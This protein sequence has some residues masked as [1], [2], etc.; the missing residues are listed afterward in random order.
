RLCTKSVVGILVV[1]FLVPSAILLAP[2]P[3][4][5]DSSCA[6][7]VAGAVAS[8]PT[9]AAAEK[10][11]GVTTS[12]PS[13]AVAGSVGAGSSFGTFFGNCILKPIA[14]RLAKAMLQN[15]TQSIVTWINN[16]FKNPD[17]S[18]SPSFVQNFSGLI[19]QTTDQVIGNFLTSDLGAGFLCSSFSLQVKIAI[20][21]SYLPYQQTGQCTLSQIENNVNGFIQND[22]SGGW[23]NW[24]QVTTVP[25]NNVWGATI[26]AENALTEQVANKLDVQNRELDWGKGFRSWQACQAYETPAQVRARLSSS[27]PTT[28][29]PLS[30]TK[31]GPSYA[32][33]IGV[34]LP[35]TSTNVAATPASSGPSATP[36]CT[37]WITETPGSVVE[38]QL[39]V[40]LGSGVRQLEIANDIDSIVGALTNQLMT[41]VVKGGLSLLGAN[42]NSNSNTFDPATYI[43]ALNAQVSDAQLNTA[44][45]TGVDNLTQSSGID[46]LFSTAVGTSTPTEA[47]TTTAPTVDENGNPVETNAITLSVASSTP[48]VSSSTPF[49]YEL[50]LGAN[51]SAQDMTV[52]TTLRKAG[53]VV[54][55]LS[56]FSAMSVSYGRTD[57]VI[58]TTYVTSSTDSSAVWTRVSADQDVPF[59]FRFAADKSASAP[60]GAYT[61]ETSVKDDTGAVLQVETDTF[62]IQ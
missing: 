14:V 23:D 53:S 9:L 3:T 1:S 46:A 43:S 7:V 13:S 16:G 25:Q 51:Y 37:S 34:T 52:T 35:T 57:G 36:Q 56:A 42:S 4:E 61:I 24:L 10:F 33:S 41:Q 31:S 40:A 19:N 20:A 55:F 58:S 29:N 12:R 50:N 28:V 11:L 21:Q 60:A 18:K 2:Q 49:E 48:V 5:A 22:N 47:P 44:I 27:N 26:M 6:A 8:I 54:P 15:I 62:T 38:N 17:G 45:N 59:V 39:E 32:S 30:P